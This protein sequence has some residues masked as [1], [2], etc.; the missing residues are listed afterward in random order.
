MMLLLGLVLTLLW[1]VPRIATASTD[2]SGTHSYTFICEAGLPRFTNTSDPT[3]TGNGVIE[4]GGAGATLTLSPGESGVLNPGE[5]S[6]NTPWD[7]VFFDLGE[8]YVFDSGTFGSCESPTT[9]TPTL[10]HSVSVIEGC[11]NGEPVVNFTNTGTEAMYANIGLFAQL[12]SP[13]ATVAAFWPT[14]HGDLY[15]QFDWHAYES[16]DP[17]A[18]IGPEFATGTVFLANACGATTVIRNVGGAIP[19]TQIP[20]SQIRPSQIPPTA[21]P[22][23]AVAPQPVATFEGTGTTTLDLG[24]GLLAD[25][26]LYLLDVVFSAGSDVDTLIVNESDEGFEDQGGGVFWFGGSFE[27]RY[28]LNSGDSTTRHLQVETEGSW[29]FTI[30]PFSSTVERWAGEQ[31]HGVGPNVL[32]FTGESGE[33][34]SLTGARATS[35]STSTET[36]ARRRASTK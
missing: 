5:V 24:A 6:P 21:R 13:G 4:F 27:G 8:P 25:D 18:D 16:P 14:A 34:A 36:T 30:W 15:Q 10:R 31:S 32:L 9:T 7:V 1:T 26:Q 2:S 29:T 3:S 35:S 22:P 17:M 23:T 33:S 12:V 11:N 20:P 28:L 19:P